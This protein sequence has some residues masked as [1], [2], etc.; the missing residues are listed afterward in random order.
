MQ[1]LV[2][3]VSFIPGLII[4]LLGY[5]FIEKKTKESLITIIISFLVGVVI[6][7]IAFYFEQ[8]LFESDFSSTSNFFTV[9]KEA[10]LWVALP[11]ELLKFIALFF[12]CYFS[13]SLDR[14]SD[15]ILYSLFIS[16]GF[17]T[18]ENV[19]YGYV[20]G[21]E[22]SL[23]RAFTAIPAHATFG[24]FMGIIFA[25]YHFRITKYRKWVI[26]LFAVFFVVIIHG[27]YDFFILQD[28]SENLLV[29]SLI[30]LIIYIIA[31]IYWLKKIRASKLIT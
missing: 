11:E 24:I 8:F 14:P 3:I 2:L 30:C 22:T 12:I 9:S 13:K 21:I 17:A 28:Y 27:I 26:I 19:L 29:G 1:D 20:Y 15:V 23:I 10:F 4:C 25:A 18:I 31:S 16:M 5:L 6:S 7:F